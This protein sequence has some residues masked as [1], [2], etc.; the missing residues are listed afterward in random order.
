M[1]KVSS[2]QKLKQE[3]EELYGLY[4]KARK[5][6]HALGEG[7]DGDDIIMGFDIKIP[8]VEGSKK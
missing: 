8:N 6:L 4:E 7:L 3:N 2:Y 1:K 5:R